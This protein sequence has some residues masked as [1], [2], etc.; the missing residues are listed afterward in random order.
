MS[1]IDAD[2]DWRARR[3]TSQADKETLLPP[4]VSTFDPDT[5]ALIRRT[6]CSRLS[7]GLGV[8]FST[9]A[10][11]IRLALA[12]STGTRDRWIASPMSRGDTMQ[13]G[14]GVTMPAPPTLPLSSPRA[15]WA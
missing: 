2:C 12:S 14:A 11:G 6:A 15:P 4:N 9:A 7:G 3:M 1:V 5:G 8:E 13:R 10:G